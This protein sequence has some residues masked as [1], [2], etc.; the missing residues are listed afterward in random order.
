MRGE[1]CLSLM[2]PV[3][4]TQAVYGRSHQRSDIAHAQ[5]IGSD[6]MPIDLGE[7]LVLLHS[8]NGV[9]DD[10]AFP[11]LPDVVEPLPGYNSVW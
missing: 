11:S 8:G 10:D 9:L 3:N 7:D 6:P 1:T 2:I 4:T 5:A